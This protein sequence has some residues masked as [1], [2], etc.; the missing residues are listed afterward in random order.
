MTVIIIISCFLYFVLLFYGFVFTYD[1]FEYLFIV[2]SIYWGILCFSFYCLKWK[3]NFLID[4]IIEKKIEFIFIGLLALYIICLF[5][6]FFM[7]QG[8]DKNMLSTIFIS[9]IN[10]SICSFL[11]I[12]NH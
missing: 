7:C 10:V 4:F 9:Q 5:F 12:R 2:T 3:Q 1:F 6:T 11:Y 8:L